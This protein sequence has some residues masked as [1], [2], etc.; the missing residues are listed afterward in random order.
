MYEFS[1]TF[2]L[3]AGV[4][5]LLFE[6]WYGVRQLGAIHRRIDVPVVMVWGEHDRFFPVGRIR[7][8]ADEFPDGRLEIVEGAGLFSH[9]ERPEAVAR[10]L[11]P[12]LLDSR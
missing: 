3:L 1:C 11:L 8:M 9:E 12:T 7:P 10:A 5:Y 4:V 2:V 6:R